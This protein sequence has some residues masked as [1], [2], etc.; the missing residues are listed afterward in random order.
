VFKQ[1]ERILKSLKKV[2]K[3][4]VITF[5]CGMS[6]C[7]ANSPLLPKDNFKKAD[8]NAV[9]ALLHSKLET[10]RGKFA[11]NL[12]KSDADLKSQIAS[13]EYAVGALSGDFSVTP[14]GAASY[15]MDIDVPPGTAGMTPKLSIT[16]NSQQQNGLLGVGFALQGLTSITRTP[17][18]IAQNGEIH[19]VDY[20]DRDKFS[21][22][23]QQLVAI[24][25]GYGQDQTEYRTYV[26]SQAKIVSYGE[27]GG[28]PQYFKVW[29]KGGQI[30]EY[31]KTEDSRIRAQGKDT[32]AVWALNKIQDT[33][34]NY[35]QVKYNK[36]DTNAGEFYPVEIDYTGNQKANVLPYNKVKFIY[37]DRDD[38]RIMYQAGSRITGS[39][40]LSAI[41][42]YANTDLV[43]SYRFA[44]EQSPQSGSPR[45]TSIQKCGAHICL[46]PTK[47]NWRVNEKR[48]WVGMRPTVYPPV[49][50]HYGS[51]DNGVQFT[52]LNGN[53][54]MDIVY[55]ASYGSGKGAWLFDK[56][57]DWVKSDEY[58]PPA[59]NNSGHDGYDNGMRLIDLTGNGKMDMV[60][61][62]AVGQGAWI[63]TGSG[64]EQKDAFIP[65]T[66]LVD[67][68]P[69]DCPIE[70]VDKGVRFIDVNGNGRAD[71]VQAAGWGGRH[72]WLNQ[73]DQWVA[74]DDYVSPVDVVVGRGGRDNGVRFVDLNG[75]GLTDIVE[76]GY[77]GN[78]STWLNDGH[79]HWVAANKDY[80][81]PVPV[82]MGPSSVTQ[83][84]FGDCSY[85]NPP[86]DN[87]VRF[88]DV[89][90]DGLPD[91]VQS[92]SAGAKGVWLNTGTGWLKSDA[93][94][95]PVPLVYASGTTT[96]DNG[97]RFLDVTGNGLVDVIY[98]T[99]DGKVGVLINTGHSWQE[100]KDS[101][102][103]ESAIPLHD[104]GSA[105]SRV[106]DLVGDG[107]ISVLQH[108]SSGQSNGTMLLHTMPD[109]LTGITDG[110]GAKTTI[111]YQPLT[112][113]DVYTPE[114]DAVYPDMD[115]NGS[116][117]I[118]S[119][120]SSDTDKTDQK[121]P[122]KDPE[123]H[124]TTYHYTGAKSNQTGFGFLGFHKITTKDQTTGIYATVTYSQDYKNQTQ[125]KPISSAT[126]TKDGTLI[127]STTSEFALKTFGDGKVNSSYY[128]PYTKKTVKTSYTLNGDLV[129]SKITKTTLDDYANPVETLEITQD[130]TGSFVT[131]VKNTYANDTS[132]WLIGELKKAVATTSAPNQK[133]IIRTASFAYDA[134]T[135]MLSKTI[136]EPDDPAFTLT[137][138]VERDVFGNVIKNTTSARDIETRVASVEYDSTGRFILKQTN[139]LDQSVS[140]KIDPRFGKP[141]ETTDLN[142]LKTINTYDDF[143][144]LLNTLKPDGTQVTNSMY[145]Y[146][147]NSNVNGNE[148]V[149]PLSNASYFVHTKASGQPH[150]TTYYDKL[151]RKVAII[152]TGFDGQTI[153][154][155]WEYDNLGRVSRTSNPFFEGTDPKYSQVDYDILGRVTKT[156]KPN[157]ATVTLTYDQAQDGGLATV[158]KNPL[159]EKATKV[160]NIKGQMI[161]TIDHMGNVT[162]YTYDPFDNLIKMVDSA[163][164]ISTI[165]YDK[166]G[167]K[168]AINDPDKGHW[169]YV[170]DQLGQLI[171]Q[172]DAKQQTTTFK[173][174]KLGR[175]ISRTDAGGTSTWEYDTAPHGIGLLAL[176][177]GVSGVSNATKLKAQQDGLLNY[178]RSYQYDAFSRPISTQVHMAHNYYVGRV[179]YDNYGRKDTITYPDGVRVKNL[180]SETGYFLALKNLDNNTV[181]VLIDQMDAQGNVTDIDHGNGYTTHKTYDESTGY[182]TDIQTYPN[183]YLSMQQKILTKKSAVKISADYIQSLHYKYD[184]LGQVAQRDNKIANT[185]DVFGYDKLNRIQVWKHVDNQ[186][187]AVDMRTYD[188]DALGNITNKSDLGTYHY[189]RTMAG[190]HAVTSI[191]DPS[192]TNVIASYGYDA[193][194]NQTSGVLKG[195]SRTIAYTSYAKP[196]QI[197]TKHATV[198]FYYNAERTRFERVDKEGVN[199]TTTLYLGAYEVV[200]HNHNGKITTEHKHYLG[201]DNLYTKT[202]TGAKSYY[203]L[204]D[205]I[206][207]VTGIT[208][209]IGTILQ[210]FSY[211][212]FGKQVQTQGVK[213]NPVITHQGF[214]GHE[215]IESTNLIHMNGRLYDPIIGRFLSADPTIQ[216]PDN[217]Q[218]LNRYSYCVNNPLSY[219]DPSGYS[220]LGDLFSDIGHFFKKIFSN[221]T[222]RN[223][224]GIVVGIIAYANGVGWLGMAG[225]MSG[226]TAVATAVA[227]GDISAG[228]RSGM[229]AFINACAF[230]AVGDFLDTHDL[231]KGTG[232]R[233]ER[234]AVHGLV[235]GGLQ[236]AEGCSFADGFLSGAVAEAVPIDS[237][238]HGERSPLALAERAGAAAVVGGTVAAA[239]GG[240]F[241]NGAETAAFAQ[242][243]NDEMHDLIQDRYEAKARKWQQNVWD[244]NKQV[245]SALSTELYDYVS[246]HGSI[247]GDLSIPV[248]PYVNARIG[249]DIS[250][251][252]IGVHGGIGP[253]LGGAFDFSTSTNLSFGNEPEGLTESLYAE[254]GLIKN[255]GA[256][257]SV[258]HSSAGFGGGVT[259]GYI[260][261]FVVGAE[262]GYSHKFRW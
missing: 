133:A 223:I 194:G 234:A 1:L 81:L 172:T 224:L 37:E 156:I 227:T 88:V 112:N 143:G 6:I 170:Y 129:G 222:V 125:G 247:S 43:Y 65:K 198:D 102:Y 56:D 244:Q 255:L 230:H 171:S 137:K 252:G 154:Q 90:G 201:D 46:P 147:P 256:G 36:D 237:I 139:A 228:L 49:A 83:N 165:T 48:G 62:S 111:A 141:L 184:H 60:Q 32:I 15:T 107:H 134:N 158:T 135:G 207:S 79:G 253:A 50:L 204:K 12:A 179:T 183:P 167:R 99:H 34:G 25:G 242:L 94:D 215:E 199:T 2:D 200:T 73:D 71:M 219:T 180:Y 70:N 18:N 246:E 19:G 142:G 51:H 189:S 92:S 202:A 149:S 186:K 16:Y 11:A 175:T 77:G 84:N 251:D 64:W 89:N 96:Y 210:R 205:N 257:G 177:N 236:V 98:H 59:I 54:M 101:V 233:M 22:G 122:V 10:L 4:L 39:K 26:D 76:Y 28:G 93:Y 174:D 220:W 213:Q 113:T 231:G 14:A 29:T 162:H 191:T 120:T 23:G 41:E 55:Q 193:N 161:A 61:N 40:R 216:A 190:P 140:Q 66:I 169:T 3:I 168:V 150:Y 138:T 105:G 87:G 69:G 119:Q 243:F 20:T 35:L 209:E 146:E 254:G 38:V 44:Y 80:L 248:F 109:L 221:Q 250:P 239:T 164:N 104:G 78:R 95:L 116:T 208:D 7:F 203:F 163:G 185:T 262:L 192:G 31:A 178:S 259:T 152:T 148:Y 260:K 187:A 53:G 30:A 47:F 226:Y 121:S 124:V 5:F 97:V 42:V 118:V 232:H 100:E 126:Y 241:A 128:Q 103:A 153:W 67:R 195:K 127:A 85:P 173:Y 130:A 82:T 72:T 211:D 225:Y 63:N 86:R 245:K 249:I 136:T 157:T 8:A 13:S 212:P 206:G 261:G 176:V 110:L 182:M 214:T 75:N 114:H 17:S 145:W 57:K 131:H 197:V 9:A 123:Q 181:P 144:R 229:F 240:N 91:L 117:Y 217:S 45:L 52:D 132:K 155:A 188:Y 258:Y 33:S 160:T 238:A 106:V 24:K 166:L 108:D 27:Q 196:R 115:I 58:N 235:G 21:L 68:Y 218:S 151:N 159:G 74:S